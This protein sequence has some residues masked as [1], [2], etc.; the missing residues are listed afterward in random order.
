M[1]K[2]NAR[3]LLLFFLH[4][5]FINIFTAHCET[6]FKDKFSISL[7]DE[8]VEIPREIIDSY[9]KDLATLVPDAGH[10]HFDYAF[11]LQSS[12]NWFQYPYIVLQVKNVGRIPEKELKKL[13]RYILSQ[14]LAE[15]Q[16]KLSPVISDF[17][18]G[19]IYYDQQ[20]NI[21]WMQIEAFV[22][23]TGKVSGLTG[24]VPT[25]KGYI[26]ISGYSF[27]E[28]SST[29]KPVF[30]SIIKSVF[31]DLNLAYKRKW[32]DNLP[33]FI[34]KLD[35]GKILVALII[36]VFFGGLFP[37]LKSSKKNS[38]SKEDDGNQVK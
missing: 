14:N 31:I 15:T 17:K 24:L 30:Q 9:T 18:P 16:K 3:I 11:Q 12:E 35:W 33:T 20:N 1:L 5:A 26:Q 8:W 4:F 7:P 22:E 34:T 25:E 27:E 19:Q 37:A 6:L 23:A 38:K 32:S 21:I 36:G 13:P 2:I 29:Y 10:P 28:H